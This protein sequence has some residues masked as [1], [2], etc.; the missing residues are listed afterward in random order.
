MRSL[1]YVAP[2]EQPRSATSLS[3]EPAPTQHTISRVVLR[4]RIVLKRRRINRSSVC[5]PALRRLH[6]RERK[7]RAGNPRRT[8]AGDSVRPGRAPCSSGC[9]TGPGLLSRG[10][11]PQRFASA[12]MSVP[13]TGRASAGCALPAFRSVC[14][15]PPAAAAL[16][17]V[18]F[19]EK[20]T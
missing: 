10:T 19:G 3:E 9:C 17:T 16:G 11:G 1:S 6:D 13:A 7:S 2:P 12:R 14:R 15:Y 8:V 18:S 4:E 5:P 20:L